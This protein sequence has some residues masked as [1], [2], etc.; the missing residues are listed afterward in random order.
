M[1]EYGQL[2][3]S[4]WQSADIRACSDSAKLLAAYLIT[5]PHSNGLGCYRLPDGYVT[6]DF[7]WSFDTVSK[8]F[9]ELIERGF[10]QR[11]SDTDFVLLPKFLHWNPIGNPKIAAARLKE[12]AQ[13]PKS[14]VLY[15]HACWCL[16]AF[17]GPHV[18]D[19]FLAFVREQKVKITARI[20]ESIRKE[21]FER[22]GNKCAFCGSTNDLTLDHIWPRALGGDHSAENLRSLCRKC[23]SSRPIFDEEETVSK[24]YQK[25][26]ETLSKQDPTRPNPDPTQ[27]ECVLRTLVPVGTDEGGGNATPKRPNGIDSDLEKAIIAA[28]HEELPTLPQ[29]RVWSKSRR[30]QLKA[31]IDECR[32]RGK[33][34]DSADYW[35]NVFRK[36]AAS[37]FL[38]GRKGDW[39]GCDLEWILGAKNFVKIIEG[40]YD[41]REVHSDGRR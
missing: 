31:R 23:N 15:A 8:A 20:P 27:K 32:A 18:P 2:Q 34:A 40:R 36:V 30:A 37:D 3:C 14:C 7:G 39:T 21:V 11:C 41:N 16:A 9:R 28:Y 5:G 6:A 35:R 13:I 26:I 10:V 17:G 25:G 1:R 33:A 19:D 29:V 38:M 12:L 24:A 22:D 4:F